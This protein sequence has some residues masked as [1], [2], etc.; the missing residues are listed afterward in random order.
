MHVAVVAIV[1]AMIPLAVSQPASASSAPNFQLQITPQECILDILST[2]V[3]QLTAIHPEECQAVEE[4]AKQTLTS[5]DQSSSSPTVAVQSEQPQDTI[6]GDQGIFENTAFESLA[7]LLGVGDKNGSAAGPI[8]T[9][10]A[11]LATTGVIIDGA[12]FGL[13]FTRP[14]LATLRRGALATWRVVLSGV[15]R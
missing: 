5:Q 1:I 8:T 15:S 6:A 3:S 11:L 13:R 7:S 10:L 4:T 14:V 9:S 12:F 2:G